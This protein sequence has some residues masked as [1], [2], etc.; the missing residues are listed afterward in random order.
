MKKSFTY[1]ASVAVACLSLASSP[2][3]AQDKP[4]GSGPN[5]YSDCGIGAALFGETKWAAVTSNVIWDIGTTAVT[6]ATMSPETCSGKTVAVAEYII[7]TYDNLLEDTAKGE[8]DYLTAMLDIYE[9]D[10][11]SHNN[12][13]NELRQEV[14]VNISETELSAQ[15]K[16]EKAS[17]FYNAIN[18]VVVSNYSASCAV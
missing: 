9:C 3:Q 12:I 11:S 10:A 5:P 2:L 7:N 16:V 1:A 13:V 18:Q 17:D 8:G 14:S 15:S 4:V 6:S